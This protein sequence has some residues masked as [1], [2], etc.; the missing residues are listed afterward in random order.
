MLAL[1][2][3]VPPPSFVTWAAGFDL[4]GSIGAVD[5]DPDRDGLRNGLECVLGL[6]PMFPDALAGPN[7]SLTPDTMLF[8]IPPGDDASETGEFTLTIEAGTDLLTWPSVFAVGPT[9]DASS[10]GVTVVEN[11]AAPDTITLG[12]PV[13][14]QIKAFARLRVTTSQ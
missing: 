9:T 11:G 12:I 14:G 1:L 6:D 4:S 7:V 13:G 8:H 3:T 5:A 10:P 2:S